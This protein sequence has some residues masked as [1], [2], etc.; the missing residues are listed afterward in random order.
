MALFLVFVIVFEVGIYN[1]N[2]N[3][4]MM[5]IIE[6]VIVILT[7]VAVMVVTIIIIIIIIIA[8]MT[9]MII[10]IVIVS[11]RSNCI[12]YFHYFSFCQKILFYPLFVSINV[13]KE[14]GRLFQISDTK[15]ESAFCL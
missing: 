9:V 1:G 7:I 5:I 2:H 12:N 6:I 11:V 3:D 13:L 10:R 8:I 14:F 4:N 15:R